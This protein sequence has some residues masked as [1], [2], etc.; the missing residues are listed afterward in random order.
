M[1]F[2]EA[3]ENFERALAIAQAREDKSLEEFMLEGMLQLSKAMNSEFKDIE[4]RLRTLEQLV[5][6]LD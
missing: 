2:R 3:K 6:R 4:S 5:R 1:S